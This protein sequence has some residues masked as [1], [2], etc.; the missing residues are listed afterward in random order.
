MTFDLRMHNNIRSNAKNKKMLSLGIIIL[1]ALTEYLIIYEYTSQIEYYMINIFDRTSILILSIISFMIILVSF[2]INNR[3]YFFILILFIL[4]RFSS[5]IIPYLQ[6]YALYGHGDILTH[7]GYLGQ[8]IETGHIS[9]QIPSRYPALYTLLS[10]LLIVSN[11][12]HK[13]YLSMLFQPFSCSL[14]ILFLSMLYKSQDGI[15]PVSKKMYIYS[16][17]VAFLCTVGMFGSKVSPTPYGFSSILIPLLML[18]LFKESTKTIILLLPL[19][20][21]LPQFHPLIA[22]IIIAYFVIDTILS[23]IISLEKAKTTNTNRI[24]IL[25]ITLLLNWIIYTGILLVTAIKTFRV[26]MA[27]MQDNIPKSALYIS[28]ASKV[29]L[30]LLNKIIIATMYYGEFVIILILSILF[31]YSMRK[32]R[33]WIATISA[34]LISSLTI[35]MFLVPV[36]FNPSRIFYVVATV[37]SLSSAVYITTKI[38]SK[39]TLKR[40]KWIWGT[41]LSILI[42]ISMLDS[43]WSPLNYR[44]NDKVPID[45]ITSAQWMSNYA[46]QKIV[47]HGLCEMSLGSTYRI[48]NYIGLL[49]INKYDV[50]IIPDHFNWKGA[51]RPCYFATYLR[52]FIIYSTLY[53]DISRY[54]PTDYDKISSSDKYDK[55]YSAYG[56]NVWRLTSSGE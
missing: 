13:N 4:L 7:L 18:I 50:L 30:S 52:V 12:S 47:N 23:C 44:P 20:I 42:L 14:Y 33:L 38:T 26:I 36:G 35:V 40:Y 21:V 22:S 32:S 45:E 53:K 16:L 17:M 34:L 55:L 1:F 41:L 2:S 5:L 48:M 19:Y 15:K 46:Y 8:V 27:F 37:F 28:K 51:K 3:Y 49:N 11:I 29:H 56:S 25:I 31:V 9:E 39:S 6:G 54:T 43:Y 24:V 10:T